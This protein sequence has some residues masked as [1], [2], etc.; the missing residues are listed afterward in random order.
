VV[1]EHQ[2]M[3]LGAGEQIILTHRA[4][5]RE[6]FCLGA[7]DAVRFVARAKPGL[8]SMADVFAEV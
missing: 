8:Y 6:H 2:V 7:L 5:S 4:T 3:F 1:G